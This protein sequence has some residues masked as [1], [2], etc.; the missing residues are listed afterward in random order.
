MIKKA[1]HKFTNLIL[2]IF[3]YKKQR[4]R[5]IDEIELYSISIGTICGTDGY[6]KKE[7]NVYKKVK[8]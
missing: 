5:V 4:I 8:K 3:G 6:V 2:N 1:W 7:H